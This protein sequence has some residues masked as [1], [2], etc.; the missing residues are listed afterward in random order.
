MCTI[1]LFLTIAAFHV[2][3][4]LPHATVVSR[5]VSLA[6]CL[7]RT[8][9][10]VSA[11]FIQYSCLALDVV[12]LLSLKSSVAALLSESMSASPSGQ[13]VSDRQDRRVVMDGDD[14]AYDY[15]STSYSSGLKLDS[16]TSAVDLTLIRYLQDLQDADNPKGAAAGNGDAHS[17]KYHTGRLPNSRTGDG[18]PRLLLMG[19]RRWAFRLPVSSS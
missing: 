7:F 16:R 15:Y 14:D 11:I 3:S 17:S 1:R 10:L 19:Q 13:S 2:S 9:N 12:C 18:K 4:R 5:S 6:I 8:L